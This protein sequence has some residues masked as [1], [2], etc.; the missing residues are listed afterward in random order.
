M[1]KVFF[2]V[3]VSLDGYLAGPNA[4][5]G[6]PLGDGGPGIHAWMFKTAAFREHLGMTGG[7]TTR[8]DD[9]LRQVFERTGAYVLGR[10]MFAEGEV[11][12]PETAPFRAPVF[13]LTHHA[14][15]PW[16]RPGGTTFF[17]VTEGIASA[18]AQARAAAGAKD[19]RISGGAATIRQFVAAG[20]IDEFTLHVAPVILG[21]G[22]K[23]MD[24]LRPADLVAEQVEVIASPLATHIRYRVLRGPVA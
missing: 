14:R 5:P 10:R 23:L 21:G 15:E 11:G 1:G 9:V 8:D 13:V 18:L 22:V 12:W 24:P 2:D 6:N 7:E 3:G 17:F 4:R 19:V 16:P 20:L